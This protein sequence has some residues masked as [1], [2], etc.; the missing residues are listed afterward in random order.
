MA[1]E[2]VLDLPQPF[3]PRDAAHARVTR[4]QLVQAR[5]LGTVDRLARGLYAVGP[6]WDSLSPEARH[7]GLAHAAHR[8][9]AG[10]VLSHH[11]AAL[12][13]GLPVP[14]RAQSRAALT[15]LADRRTSVAASWVHLYRA[16]LRDEDVTALDGQRLTS[17]HRTVLDCLRSLAPGDGV[18][19]GD[20]ALRAGLVS[21]DGLA[22]VLHTQRG[23]PG[24]RRA[25]LWIPRL[26]GRRETWLESYSVVTLSRFGI[27]PPEPQVEVYDDHGLIG[28]VDGLWLAEGVVG[29]A[30]GAGK[31]LG[32]FDADGADGE[33]AA[34]RVVREKVREDRLRGVGLEVVRWM[35]DE[36]IRA[37]QVVASRVL[38][39]QRRGDPSRFRGRVRLAAH[40]TP[41]CASSA[42]VERRVSE[43]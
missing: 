28:R 3:T 19:V 1:T 29:E 25:A 32:D 36:I 35:T 34:K 15:V 33:A 8:N 31:Y 38:A 42:R 16:T 40:P 14:R 11:S 22:E 20:A 6:R 18:A 26:D 24:A 9:V 7:E 23:W 30:D 4:G 2:T 39:A 37:P 27:E 41:L 12:L 10:A 21:G 5:K 17:P 43:F 13:W